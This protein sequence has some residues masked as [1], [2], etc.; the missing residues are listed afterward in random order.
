MRIPAATTSRSLHNLTRDPSSPLSLFDNFFRE[1]FTAPSVPT[2]RSHLAPINIAEL[3]DAISIE[4]ELPGVPESDIDVEVLGNQLT[5]R[6]T[7]SF[8]GKTEADGAE[9]SERGSKDYHTVEHRYGSMSRR[10]ELPRGLDTAAID[11]TFENGV[12]ALTIP[13]TE[14]A[15]PKK[16][17]IRT[18]GGAGPAGPDGPAAAD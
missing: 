12:L 6:A 14:P 4:V 7:R 17:N 16:I 9:Q 2:E 15:T 3:E 13:K 1:F 8:N 18:S 5:I 10:V 11:A